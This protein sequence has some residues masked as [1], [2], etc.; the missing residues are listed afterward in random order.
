MKT[1]TCKD[2]RDILRTVHGGSKYAVLTKVD[3]DWSLK[4]QGDHNHIFQFCNGCWRLYRRDG[5]KWQLVGNA[6]G[7]T[8][9]LSG[10]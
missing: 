3:D 2:I 9:L 5:D 8:R 4:A 10:S 1:Y 6:D 7:A